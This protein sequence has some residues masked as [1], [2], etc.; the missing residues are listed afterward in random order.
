MAAYFLFRLNQQLAAIE[1][2]CVEEVFAIPELTLI[3]DAPLGIVGV[4]D[5][6]GE[7]LPVLDL[8]LSADRQHQLTDNVL[9]L[10]H[11]DLKVGIIVSAAQGLRE[12]STEAIAPRVAEYQGL[13][14]LGVSDMLAG[15]VI[16]AEPILVLNNP[17]RWLNTNSIQQ[18]V[19]VTSFLIDKIHDEASPE[20][21]FSAA[22]PPEAQVVLRR[23]AE[24]LRRLQGDSD[25][26]EDLTN[27]V[28]MTVGGQLFGIDAQTAREFIT[29]NQAMPIP[30]CPPHIVGSVNLR[31]EILTVLDVCQPLGLPSSALARV[32]KAV[33]VEADETAVAIV[34]DDVRDAMF[35]LSPREVTQ[36]PQKAIAVKPDYV[37]G[38]A[39]YDGEALYVL[40]LPTLL[41]SQEVVVNEML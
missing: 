35:S 26:D 7:I 22:F 2:A 14:R 39:S 6:R 23:R 25:A 1:A 28:V 17:K 37:Q 11:A 18:V 36:V 9:V 30:C 29:V 8:R 33:V 10:S 40:D 38:V 21:S 19:S 15:V 12:I 24:E 34:V 31:G 4:L 5:L 16:E 20:A 3:P 13:F 27:M 41:K 32:P